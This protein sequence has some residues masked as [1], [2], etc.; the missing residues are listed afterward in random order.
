MPEIEFV[1]FFFLALECTVTR[2]MSVKRT[3][4]LGF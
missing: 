3:Y 1:L 2:S 4:L